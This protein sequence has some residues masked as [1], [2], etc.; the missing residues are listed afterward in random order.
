MLP[1]VDESRICQAVC[2]TDVT[3]GSRQ[4]LVF[5]NCASNRWYAHRIVAN[6]H[7]CGCCLAVNSLRMSLIIHIADLHTYIFTNV[8]IYKII[9]TGC[10]VIDV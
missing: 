7:N 3:C 2:I 4:S 10:C 1:L 6:A 9:C 5:L 8:T